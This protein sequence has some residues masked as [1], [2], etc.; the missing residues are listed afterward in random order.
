[1]RLGIPHAAR[2]AAALLLL[3]VALS[4]CAPLG[5]V[6]QLRRELTAQLLVK[7]ATELAEEG[8]PEGRA[9]QLAAWAMQLAP[10]DLPVLRSATLVFLDGRAWDRGLAALLAVQEKTGTVDLYELGSCYLYLGHEE[11]GA[12]LLEKDLAAQRSLLATHHLS[13]AALAETL[14]NIGYTYADAGVRL[15]EAL[16]LTKEAV[17]YQPTNGTFLDSLGWAYCR[18][19]QY[20]S[21]AFALEQALRQQRPPEADIFFH[22][23]LVHARLGQL[24]LARRELNRAVAL[25]GG[26]F[27]E[28]SGE[29]QRM[30]WQLPEPEKA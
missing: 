30:K 9:V 20:D 12:A 3:T 2:P 8:R 14:N 5:T 15:D 25:R 23:G 4:G 26:D 6:D 19:G 27:P 17:G 29:L 11:Q 13:D 21:A 1:V 28:A 22:A 24:R 7:Q 18:L 16:A 10:Q